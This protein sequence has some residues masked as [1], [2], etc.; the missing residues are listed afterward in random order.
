M[1]RVLFFRN[2]DADVWLYFAGGGKLKSGVRFDF[3]G[4]DVELALPAGR[5]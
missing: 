1:L 3:G 5:G 2:G 4:D